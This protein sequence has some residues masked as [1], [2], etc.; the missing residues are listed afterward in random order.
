MLVRNGHSSA[1]RLRLAGVSVSRSAWKG[2]RIK[3]KRI[4]ILVRIDSDQLEVFDR[5]TVTQA[6]DLNSDRLITG[7]DCFDD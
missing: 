6:C 1:S 2:Q 3:I 7:L 5:R 4:A